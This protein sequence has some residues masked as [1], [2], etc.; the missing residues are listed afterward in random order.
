MITFNGDQS[1]K[2]KYINRLQLHYEADQII[3]GT[4]WERGKGCAVG[5]TVHSSEHA[6][7]EIELGIPRILAHLEDIFFEGMSNADAKK[8]PL[9]FLNA[10][11][12]GVDLKDVYK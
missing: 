7:Y 9:H 10:V 3:Q 5:C 2:E 11:P 12:V 1:I 4:Y 8:F 6:R